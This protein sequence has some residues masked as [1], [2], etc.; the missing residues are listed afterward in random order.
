MG[1]PS[2]DKMQHLKDYYI[3]A[4]HSY[5][6]SVLSGERIASV[7]EHQK[8]RR[9]QQDMEKGVEGFV[10]DWDRAVRPLIWISL[11]LVFPMGAKRGKRFKLEPFQ[12]FDIMCVFGWIKSDNPAERRFLD[13]YYQIARKNG[14]STLWGAVLDYLAFCEARGVSCYI[15]ATSLDQSEETF[16]RAADALTVQHLAKLQNSKQMGVLSRSTEGGTEQ[17]EQ[18]IPTLA[19]KGLLDRYRAPGL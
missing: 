19:V 2:A 9:Q 6:Q 4:Y 11:N 1:K 18:N 10:W 5:E 15:G 12:A 13:V 16:K 3:S 14:K 8:I 7:A 17:L